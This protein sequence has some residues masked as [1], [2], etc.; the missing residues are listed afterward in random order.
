MSNEWQLLRWKQNIEN[1]E[2]LEDQIGQN[3]KQKEK[4]RKSDKLF[5]RK[6]GHTQ[7][8]DQ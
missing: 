6:M 1:I 2:I 4:K 8:L 7:N 5:L 3:T